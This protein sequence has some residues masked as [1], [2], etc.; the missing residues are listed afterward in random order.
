MSNQYQGSQI[1]GP[2][3]SPVPGIGVYPVISIPDDLAD[4]LDSYCF[5]SQYETIA[6]FLE[7]LNLSQR[8][9][10]GTG[11]DGEG[12]YDNIT[13]TLTRD[14]H[15]KNLTV[16]SSFVSNG[17]YRIYVD[18]TCYIDYFSA[19]HSNGHNASGS[20]GGIP[21]AQGTLRGGAE[22]AV[23]GIG[24]NDGDEGTSP[25]YSLGAGNGGAGADGGSQTGG[26]GGTGTGTTS[27]Q[28][29]VQLY[30]PRYFGSIVSPNLQ[31]TPLAGGASGGGGGGAEFGIGGGGGGGGGFLCIAA[32]KIVLD[33]AITIFAQGGRGAA[34]SA[35]GGGGGGGGGGVILLAYKSLE[36]LDGTTLTAAELCG[37]G[38]GGGTGMLKG[39]DG[40]DGNIIQIQV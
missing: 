34:G 9:S 27:N 13:T 2:N 10:F 6:D 18:G 4:P 14:M 28:G 21:S 24:P 35:G 15:F 32:R 5:L 36:I 23:G 29:R 19:V 12:I 16:R 39:T 30:S 7:Y 31:V 33:S 1:G 3:T 17:G 38:R 26:I 8:Q 22:G 25:G 20:T 11:R 37:G 40:S